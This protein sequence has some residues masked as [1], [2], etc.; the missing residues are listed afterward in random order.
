MDITV[1][2]DPSDRTIVP[3]PQLVEALAQNP[4]EKEVFDNLSPST[5]K[6]IVRYI[7]RL[8]TEASVEKN[9]TK[10]IEFLSG[11]GTFIGRQKLK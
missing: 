6:E 11:K 1:A 9:I 4:K 5:Q 2:F 7:S 3:H 10:A 8:K